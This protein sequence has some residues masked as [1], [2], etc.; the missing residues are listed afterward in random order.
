[1]RASIP[2]LFCLMVWS[3][4]A[5]WVQRDPNRAG[6]GPGLTN[7]GSA[8]G[9]GRQSA[10]Q[11][12]I[13]ADWRSKAVVALLALGALTPIYEINRSLYRTAQ[14]YLGAAAQRTGAIEY[15]NHLS[16]RLLPSLVHPGR[17]EA[18]AL[19]SLAHMRDLVSR[20]F[21]A[22][23]RGSLFDTYLSRR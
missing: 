11:V 17:L 10:R 3:G 13:S 15:V 9:G 5:L 23:V 6:P 14:Y 1:M 16:P 18:D 8:A 2:T 20:N 22:N 19:G 7:Q 4:E 12:L 21:V